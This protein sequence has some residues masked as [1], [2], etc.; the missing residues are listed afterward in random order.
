MDH[1]DFELALLKSALVRFGV[2]PSDLR[3]RPRLLRSPRIYLY[4]TVL[5]T[6]A[7]RPYPLPSRQWRMAQRWNDLLFAH[8]PIAAE[9]LADRLPAGLAPDLYDGRAW[10]GVIPFWMDRV[11]VRAVGERTVWFPGTRSFPELNLRTYVRSRRTGQQGVYF[12]SLDAG[13]LL[14]VIGARVLFHLP[15]FPAS[16]SRTTSPAGE[17]RYRSR[18]SVPRSRPAEVQVRYGPTGPVR[19]SEPGD[20][21]S[22]L[23]ERYC[24][25]TTSPRG[26]LLVGEIH[27]QQWPLQPAEAEF[28]RNDL[29][30][31][32]G[33]SLPDEPPVL[34]FAR[35]L[36]VSIWSLQPEG[37]PVPATT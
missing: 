20:L 29:P 6:T 28:L 13:S 8:W 5:E 14:A 27:H 22:F 17:I 12:F 7:H 25:F 9:A 4:V 35:N 10:L 3:S 15:Y 18:R 31:D 16:M 33:F 34:H 21:A 37:E 2:T 19:Q 36:E 30:A 23:T 26:Q 24:L 11:R 1:V 32:F